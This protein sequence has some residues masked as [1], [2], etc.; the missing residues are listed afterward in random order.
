M[1]ILF[2]KLKHIGD[3]LLLTPTL[4]ATR[5][6]YPEA[7]IWVVVR[8]GCDGILEGC[9]AIDRLLTAVPPEPDKRSLLYW[10]PDVGLIR[11]LRRQRFDYAFELSDGDRGRWISYL[12]RARNRCASKP[13]QPL[14]WWWRRQFTFISG[15]D[16]PKRHRV[17]KDFFTVND[18]LPLGDEIPPLVFEQ[19]ATKPSG[20]PVR[21]GAY[22]L[23]HPGTRWQRKRWPAEK[24]IE[25]GQFL[26]AHVPQ[27]VISVGPDREETELAAILRAAFGAKAISTEGKLSW[28]Q[29]AGLLYQARLF[30]GVDTAAMHLAAACECPTVAIFGPSLV[31]QWRPWQVPNQ[32]VTPPSLARQ[33]VPEERL[34]EAVEVHDVQQACKA[35]LLAASQDH[36]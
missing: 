10:L 26:L 33:S 27:L 14:N 17:E 4:A 23:L 31:D 9:P 24:W 34:T 12:S 36:S 2:I 3:A 21:P 25:L 13:A 32:V 6:R 11:E 30:V 5:K 15:F 16:W 29:L 7:S 35:M 1:R 18:T 20:L 8:K 19:T 28:A 22:A